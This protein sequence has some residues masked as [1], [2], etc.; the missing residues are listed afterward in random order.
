[1]LAV[2]LFGLFGA[3]RVVPAHAGTAP[4]VIKP[5]YEDP[6]LSGLNAP[7]GGEQPNGQPSGGGT[8]LTAIIVVVVIVVFLLGMIVLNR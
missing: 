5:D 1:M 2:I 7:S 6:P 4:A 8:P 3:A